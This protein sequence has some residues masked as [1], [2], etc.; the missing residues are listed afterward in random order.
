MVKV[1]ITLSTSEFLR[2][3]KETKNLSLY[4]HLN[5]YC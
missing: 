5:N 3:K 4:D 2:K 1:L